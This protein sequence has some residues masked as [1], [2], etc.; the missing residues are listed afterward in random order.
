MKS[1]LRKIVFYIENVTN[2]KSLSFM[3]DNFLGISNRSARSQVEDSTLKSNPD[4]A[5][6]DIEGSEIILFKV[7]DEAFTRVPEYVVEV[8]SDEL[9]RM[10]SEKWKRN[11]YE[12]ISI[13]RGALSFA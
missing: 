6:M 2:R 9:P 13:T 12:A 5:E 1:I 8:H 4:V 11:N 3:F 7:S 10:I